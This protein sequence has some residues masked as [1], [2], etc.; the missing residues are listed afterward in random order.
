MILSAPQCRSFIIVANPLAPLNCRSTL[1]FSDLFSSILCSFATI[2]IYIYAYIVYTDSPCPLQGDAK[3]MSCPLF[4]VVSY[5]FFH[6]PPPFV[7]VFFIILIYNLLWHSFE[8]R[9][10]QSGSGWAWGWVAQQDA[11]TMWHT[12]PR[13]QESRILKRER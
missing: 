9:I 2:Y 11:A 3:R 13:K 12:I 8:T 7:F 10:L 1:V 4:Y 5:L 6:M